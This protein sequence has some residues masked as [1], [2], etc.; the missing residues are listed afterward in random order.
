MYTSI[1]TYSQ[2]EQIMKKIITIILFLSIFVSVF[3]LH[4]I[5]SANIA[6][7][8]TDVEISQWYYKYVETVYTYGIMQGKS[9]TIFAPTANMSR[10]EFVTVLCRLSGEE[11]EGKC[12]N[13]GFSDTDKKAWYADYVAWGVETEMVKGLPGNRFAP[14]QAVSRQEMAVFIDRFISYMNLALSDNSQIDAFG[15]GEKVADYA[16]DAVDTMRKSGIITGNDKGNFNPTANASRAEVATV[17]SRIILI[18]ENEKEDTLFPYTVYLPENYSS[19]SQYPLVVYVSVYNKNGVK[20]LFDSDY[21]PANDSIVIVPHFSDNNWSESDSD[22]FE[23]FISYIN[24]KYSTDKDS[25]YVIAIDSGGFIAWRSMLKYPD[26]FTAALF[27]QS[28]TLRFWNTNEGY[29]AFEEDI[30]IKMADMPIHIVHDTTNIGNFY[31][32]YGKRVY[33]ALIKAGYVNVQLKETTG[34]GDRIANNF[35]TKDD[36]SLLEWLFTQRRETK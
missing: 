10:S 9:P 31:P 23:V 15:D 21:S 16:K 22:K 18:L 5:S 26:L 19:E 33:D 24:S 32:D 2:E 12:N 6:L 17:I 3:G 11:Y 20:R 27:V 28:A 4:I 36:I 14:N 8:F 13:L 1:C 30:N 25:Q 7:P 35:V 34:Y 29:V